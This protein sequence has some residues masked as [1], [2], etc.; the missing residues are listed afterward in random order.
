MYYLTYS[1]HGWI[2]IKLVLC[3][4]YPYRYVVVLFNN[5]INIMH[6]KYL[7]TFG[8]HVMQLVN[9]YTWPNNEGIFYPH[10]NQSL[11]IK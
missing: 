1:S 4:P 8:Q 9:T 10:C 5:G 6:K 3:V 2:S 7:F 11:D